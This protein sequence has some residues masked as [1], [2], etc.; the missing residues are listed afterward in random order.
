MRDDLVKAF[1]KT[2]DLV[3]NS[4]CKLQLSDQ[5]HVFTLQ[6]RQQ[7][8]VL[9]LALLMHIVHTAYTTVDMHILQ[10][11]LHILWWILHILRVQSIG[12]YYG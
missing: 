12:T 3:M 10:L 11:I 9:T 5:L 1:Q 8:W 4:F 2:A 7:V 6:W